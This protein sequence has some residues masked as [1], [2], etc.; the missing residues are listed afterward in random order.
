MRNKN[1]RRAAPAARPRPLRGAAD[2]VVRGDGPHAPRARASPSR[3]PRRRPRGSRRRSTLAERLAARGLRRRAAPGGPDDVR[4]R[5][6][7]R[8]LRPADR[9]RASARSSCRPATPTR[10]PATT[11]PR[12]TCCED[13]DELGRPFAAR[14]HHRLPRVA[15]VDPRRPHRAGDVGQAPH[16]THVV[17]NL[18][19]DPATLS[20]VG[21]SGC[22]RAASPCRCCVG[23]P[24]PVDRTKLLGDGDQDR[25]GGV[26]AVPRQAPAARSPGWRR[27]AASPASGSSSRRCRGR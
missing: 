10:R 7:R 6:A 25:R 18:T 26:D 23:V 15:P 13:L 16:A 21:A 17:S 27:P 19:F 12:S 24:G 9:G 2:A 20:D 3:S 14:R 4:P 1:A 22:A 5:R 11:T 8:D